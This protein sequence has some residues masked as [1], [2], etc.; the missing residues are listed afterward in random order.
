M[1]DTQTT[2]GGVHIIGRYFISKIASTFKKTGGSITGNKVMNDGG[3]QVYA[4]T[5]REGDFTI[6]DQARMDERLRL[7]HVM[8]IDE[9]LGE[10]A[11]LAYTVEPSPD[12]VPNNVIFKGNWI[13]LDDVKD[14]NVY[15]PQ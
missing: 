11:T 2:G 14:T 7:G 9:A 6:N 12:G 4:A 1:G 8:K 3:H 5:F 10:G 15:P 13:H